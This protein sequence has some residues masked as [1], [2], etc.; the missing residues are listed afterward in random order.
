MAVVLAT[1]GLWLQDP[2]LGITWQNVLHGEQGLEIHDEIPAVA[3]VLGHT[4]V[5]KIIDRGESK[6]AFI[7]TV[8]ELRDSDSGRLL[9]TSSSTEICRRDGGCG[10][11]EAFAVQV[12]WRRQSAAC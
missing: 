3:S 12:E 11:S 4:R 1:P 10:G 8:T 5:E 7:Y 2:S 6:G 9:A